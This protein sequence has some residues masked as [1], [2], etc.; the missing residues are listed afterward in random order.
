MIKLLSATVVLLSLTLILA[1]T[2]SY[3]LVV[4]YVEATSEEIT[5][6]ATVAGL[7]VD[8]RGDDRTIE[9]RP[10][11]GKPLTNQEARLQWAND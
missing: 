3:W 4:A 5:V 8:V 9:V 10:T 7:G 11:T 2:I 1:I 6:T